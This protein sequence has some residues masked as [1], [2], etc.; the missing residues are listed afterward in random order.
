[1]INSLRNFFGV[2][3]GIVLGGAVN[4]GIIMISSKIIPPP[5][6]TDLTTAEGLNAAMPML[7][8]KHFIMPFLAH[9]LGTFVGA[10]AAASMA[11]T[12]KNVIAIVIGC[13][14]L[15]GGIWAVAI[16]PA[17]VWF[18]VVDLALAYLPM[19]FLAHKFAWKN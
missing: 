11:A 13:V 6:G 12:R 8:A 17:P 19:A 14:N 15:F 4:M 3:L 5:A 18:D 1:M 9:A 2:I 16:I 10:F 7:E